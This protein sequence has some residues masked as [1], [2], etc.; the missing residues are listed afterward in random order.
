[1]NFRV[2]EIENYSTDEEISFQSPKSY[3]ISEYLNPD[4]TPMGF[5]SS[6]HEQ[7]SEPSQS[8]EQRNH[9][10]EESNFPNLPS[11]MYEAICEKKFSTNNESIH[12]TLHTSPEFQHF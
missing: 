7:Q 2:P 10:S 12:I 3:T 5:K 9:R 6:I 4:D 11:A 8:Q 1:M